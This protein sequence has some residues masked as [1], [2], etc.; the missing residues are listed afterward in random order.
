MSLATGTQLGPYKILGPLGAGGMGEVYQAQDTKLGREVAIKVLPKTFAGDPDRLSRFEREAR[1]LASLNHP[2]IAA[3]YDLEDIENIRFLVLE[4]VPGETLSQKISGGAIP[5][6]E[7]LRLS[8]QIAKALEAAHSRGIIHRDLKP[9]NIMVTPEDKIKVLDFGLAKGSSTTVVSSDSSQSPT[10]GIEGTTPGTI[11]GTATYMSPEQ[12]RG[13][14]VD[15]RSDIWAFGC[16]LFEMLSGQKP[17]DGETLSDKIVAIL[18]REPDWESIPRDVPAKTKELLRR[19]LE[20]DIDRRLRDM[21]EAKAIVEEVLG[22][23]QRVAPEPASFMRF[24]KKALWGVAVLALLLAIATAWVALGTRSNLRPM[25]PE[26]KFLVVLPFKDLSGQPSGQ[27]MGDGMVETLSARLAQ[28]PDIQVVVP[29]AAVSTSDKETDPFRVA[30]KLGAN[31]L[32]QGSLQR[33]GDR[34]RITFSVWNTR[35]RTEIAGDT[36]DGSTSDLFSMQDRL[37]ENLIS[38]LQM[39]REPQ[40]PRQPGGLDTADEQ[41]QYLKAMGML[42][43]YD[44]EASVDDALALLRGLV[45]E[46]PNVAL[47]QAAMGR[48]CLLKFNLTRDKK[49]IDGAA[50]ACDHAQQVNPNS[51]EVDVTVGELRTASG[52]TNEAISA[53]RQALAAQP[54]NFE[55]WLGLAS[56]YEAADNRREAEATY[57]RAMELQPSYWAGYSKLGG[58]YYRLG[59]YA[60][61]AEMFHRVTELSPDNARAFSNLGGVYQLM[62]DFGKALAAYKQSLALLPTSPAYSNI[63]TLEFFN[64]HPKEAAD[65]Y[66]AALKLTPDD[67][68]IWA[69][70]GDAY[71]WAPGLQSKAFTAYDKAI[72]L[73]QGEL[74][75]NPKAGPVHSVLGLSLAKTGKVSEAEAQVQKALAIDPHNPEF[76]FNAAVVANLAHKQKEALAWILLASKNG[77]PKTFIAREAEFENLRNDPA[78]KEAVQE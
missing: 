42:Q 18:T 49:W 38:S 51:P 9:L 72:S 16:I 23:T 24:G 69:N 26:K 3:I 77:F 67:Y 59:N 5:H 4:F 62:G 48:A 73:C 29:S 36:V 27:L 14:P 46:K 71:R 74:R 32:L 19:C 63:G 47:V 25:I 40:R 8:R 13:K 60:Q 56:A 54:N 70:L 41:E 44:K 78:F 52:Q 65:A 37:A 43:R 15:K 76:L 7:A 33:S 66:E 34:L 1:V 64:G 45:K 50:S 2:N 21:G 10:M 30:E 68:E 75:L 53:F 28:V 61:A 35:L 31:L 11:L 12:A 22:D 39:K 57:R 58:F 55:A 6:R 20:K 17:F